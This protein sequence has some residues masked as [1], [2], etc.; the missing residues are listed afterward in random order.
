MRSVGSLTIPVARVGAAMLVMAVA[1]R[2][3]AAQNVDSGRVQFA[4]HCAGCHGGNAAGGEHGP[5]LVDIPE[6][7]GAGSRPCLPTASA[8]SSHTV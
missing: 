3:V 7:G 6:Q 5:D 8:R 2:G 1:P 4:S